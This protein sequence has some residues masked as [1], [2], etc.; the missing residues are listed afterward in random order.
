MQRTNFE[1]VC[2]L[3]YLCAVRQWVWTPPPSGDIP[4]AD[5]TNIRPI[6]A[7][8]PRCHLRQLGTNR[9]TG[10]I[11]CSN[12]LLGSISD[13]KRSFIDLDIYFELRHSR[14]AGPKDN[15]ER[16]WHILLRHWIYTFRLSSTVIFSGILF[17][18]TTCHQCLCLRT[19][20]QPYSL[21]SVASFK[22]FGVEVWDRM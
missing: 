11:A 12:I 4:A 22:D 6:A 1:P 9:A 5:V 10:H 21:D 18:L 20:D 19:C 8:L 16:P 3:S 7:G 15:P 13:Q 17:T 14:H 2:L